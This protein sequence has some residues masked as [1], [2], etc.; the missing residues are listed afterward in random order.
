MSAGVGNT[1]VS[2]GKKEGKGA[3]HEKGSSHRIHRGMADARQDDA[4]AAHPGKGGDHT[5]LMSIP[6]PKMPATRSNER[7]N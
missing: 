1:C 6:R 3:R 4:L 7:L 5:V 2:R